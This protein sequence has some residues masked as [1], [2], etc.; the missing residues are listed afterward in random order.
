LVSRKSL[1]DLPFTWRRLTVA[2]DLVIQP[3]EVAQAF[4]LQLGAQQLVFYRS[5]AQAVRRSVLGLHLNSEFYAGRFDSEDTAY[6]AI[7]EISSDE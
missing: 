6:E 2:E 5:L 7:V 3:A 1:R 4:R